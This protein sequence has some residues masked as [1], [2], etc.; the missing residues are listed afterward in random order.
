MFAWRHNETGAWLTLRARATHTHADQY[1][2]SED[3]ND[4][5]TLMRPG[6]EYRKVC[7]PV[8]VEVGRTVTIL[9]NEFNRRNTT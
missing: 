7:T 2:W 6:L 1:G 9:N 4:A 8:E 3:I 5:T